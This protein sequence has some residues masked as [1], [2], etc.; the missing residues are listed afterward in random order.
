VVVG[1]S[2]RGNCCWSSPAQKIVWGPVGFMAIFFSLT[3]LG[4]MH[5]AAVVVEEH[6]SQ[7]NH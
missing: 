1:R 2:G 7:I 5:V 4:D 6:C 3:T